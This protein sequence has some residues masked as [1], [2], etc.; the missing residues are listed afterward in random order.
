M[1]SIDQ[2]LIVLGPPGA[3]DLLKRTNKGAA[4]TGQTADE[5]WFTVMSDVLGRFCE[6]IDESPSALEELLSDISGE[7]VTIDDAFVTYWFDEVKHPALQLRTECVRSVSGAHPLRDAE[8][9]Q[10]LVDA[11]GY[12]FR[13][14]WVRAQISYGLPMHDAPHTQG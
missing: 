14:Q 2:V 12:L 10:T 6:R 9:I 8:T 3:D 4:R 13:A 5:L 7:P 1:D 11:V